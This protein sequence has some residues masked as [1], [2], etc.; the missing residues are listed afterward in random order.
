M[1][2]AWQV[3]QNYASNLAYRDSIDKVSAT[4]NALTLS[5]YP[6]LLAPQVIVIAQV[7]YFPYAQSHTV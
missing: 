2:F 4:V 1:N 7:L 3:G 6:L 5:I